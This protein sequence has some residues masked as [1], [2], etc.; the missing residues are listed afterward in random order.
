M[1]QIRADREVFLSAVLLDKN[2]EV[3]RKDPE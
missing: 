1:L 2:G 3:L